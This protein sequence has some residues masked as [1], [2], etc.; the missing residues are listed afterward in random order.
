MVRLSR[1][2]REGG[3]EEGAAAIA[4]DVC[5]CVYR[6]SVYSRSMCAPERGGG[7]GAGGREGGREGESNHVL[8]ANAH[9]C[10]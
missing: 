9:K 8:G 1:G 6:Q 5:I 7:G 4:A 3:G 2:C 10:L